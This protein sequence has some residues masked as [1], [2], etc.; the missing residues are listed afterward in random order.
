MNLP[1][2]VGIGFLILLLVLAAIVIISGRSPVW[3]YRYVIK[4]I[5]YRAGSL[6]VNNTIYY[7][8]KIILRQDEKQAR[9]E[10]YESYLA[11]VKNREKMTTTPNI[12]IVNKN[13]NKYTE[14][15]IKDRLQNLQRA[16]YYIHYLYGGDFPTE[17]W[18]KGR[19]LTKSDNNHTLIKAWEVIRSKPHGYYLKKRFK[20]YL[21]K[22]NIKLVSAE[23]GTNGAEIFQ[24]CQEA[25]IPLIVTFRG[26]DIHNRSIVDR[27]R[28]EYQDM[29]ASAAHVIGVS[30]DIVEKLER[31]FGISSNK[32]TYLPSPTDPDQFPY[33]D[34]SQNQDPIFLSIGRFAE[35]KSPHVLILAFFEVLKAIPQARLVMIG[36]DGGGELFEACQI[37]A[38]A[39]NIHN[40]IE[41]KGILTQDEVYRE[42]QRA[43]VF[44]QH[45][46][47]TPL[48]GDKE[49]T[50][51]AIR[52]AMLAGLPIVATR[53]AGIAE[54][55]EDG[56][57]GILV[58]EYD[59][60]R[61]AR[62]MI[63]VCQNDNK[64]RQL[65]KNAA[66]SLRN[67]PLITQNTEKLSQI[68]E[69]YRLG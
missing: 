3:W 12:A 14:T 60:E 39:L 64:V 36:Q 44:V 24:Q 62:A 7:F 32:V 25:G 43:R 30:Q 58:E 53:H 51:G 4:P 1:Q 2:S 47:T 31:E 17:D 5:G 23:F 50:P 6:I 68:I 35:T 42:M 18:D 46:L 10:H 49:G 63:E 13:Y 59:Y 54:L 66:D 52:E 11:E 56:K 55:I 67:N 61:M 19:L 20:K 48:E 57:T 65:G 28:K 33:S 45:S 37:M 26:Y 29:L 40:R 9:G 16:G 8:R 69:Q 22:Y 27:Y 15:F 21:K 34:H 38:K 41:F